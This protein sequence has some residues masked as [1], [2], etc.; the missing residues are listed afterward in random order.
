[1]RSKNKLAIVKAFHCLGQ[2]FAMQDDGETALSLFN[3]ALEGCILMDVHQWR[4]DCMVRIADIWIGCGKV[5]TAVGLWQ[6]ARPLFAR[7]S[8]A[9]D[10]AQIDAKLATVE[11]SILEHDERPVLKL[12]EL[13][14]PAQH[15]S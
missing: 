6:A 8:Q 9:R 10:V 13:N 11:A 1:L 12:A 5:S 2:I 3:L 15:E 4:A 7:S 14:V